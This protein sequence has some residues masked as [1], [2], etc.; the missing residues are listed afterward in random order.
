MRV[1]R[2]DRKITNTVELSEHLKE[3]TG[4]RNVAINH[5]M[6]YVK[7]IGVNKKGVLK[8]TLEF[9]AKEVLVNSND[10]RKWKGNLFLLWIEYS[11][12]E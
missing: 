3:V 7:K 12:G 1:S 10:I 8:V 5:F 6:N 11:E 9:D 4:A 2:M